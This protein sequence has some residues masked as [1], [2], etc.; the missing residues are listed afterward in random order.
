[1]SGLKSYLRE[2]REVVE[3][4][5]TPEEQYETDLM[6]AEH[7]VQY[8]EAEIERVEQELKAASTPQGVRATAAAMLPQTTRQGAGTL[9]FPRSA[10]RSGSS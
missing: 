4:S 3:R 5:N 2:L 1:L 7:N 6:G 9:I 8:Y 10:F